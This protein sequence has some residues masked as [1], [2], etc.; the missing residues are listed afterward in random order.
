MGCRWCYLYSSGITDFTQIIDYWRNF[1]RHWMHMI[2]TQKILWLQHMIST[3]ATRRIVNHLRNY[4]IYFYIV[5]LLHLSSKINHRIEYFEICMWLASRIQRSNNCCWKN[6]TLILKKWRKLFTW[7]NNCDKIFFVLVHLII[8]WNLL[9][10][11]S[12]ERKR[13]IN[14]HVQPLRRQEKNNFHHV[15]HVD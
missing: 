5:G 7:E 2:T 6:K 11:E 4:M 12:I 8:Q 3:P 15:N 1:I 10:Q 13:L 9:W 14:Q